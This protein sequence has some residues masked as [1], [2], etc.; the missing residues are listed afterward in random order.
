MKFWASK[1]RPRELRGLVLD[2]VNDV[3]KVTSFVMDSVEYVDKE[4]FDEEFMTWEL[5]IPDE[6]VEEAESLTVPILF[7]SNSK[8]K[9]SLKVWGETDA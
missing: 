5:E 8:R 6:I 7:N 1:K 4:K 9:Y 3:V 2:I